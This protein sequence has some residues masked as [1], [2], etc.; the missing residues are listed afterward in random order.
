MGTHG[1]LSLALLILLV[2]AATP[3]EE[4]GG[5]YT[6]INS[7]RRLRVE[8]LMQETLTPFTG[9][10]HHPS[11]KHL[12]F[13]LSALW[14]NRMTEEG[15][16]RLRQAY[17]D[18][19]KSDAE[20]PSEVMTPNLAYSQKWGNMR[21]WLRI[22]YLFNSESSHKP[23]RLAPDVE[24][25]MR[26]L[27]WNFAQM[28][29][30]PLRRTDPDCDWLIMN[31]ENH[32]IM[33]YG[34]SFLALQAIRNHPDYR[35]RK[36]EDGHT[37][38]E[39]VTAWTEYYRR[40]CDSR[41]DSGLF[42]EISP[43][44][45]KWFLPELI[46]I[47]DFADDPVLR[48]KME[49]L[50]HLT[51]ADWAIDQLGGIRGGGKTRSYPDHYSTRGGSDSWSD[52]MRVFLDQNGDWEKN[53]YMNTL[54]PYYYILGTAG[55]E[56]PDLVM[57]LALDDEARGEYEYTSLRPARLAKPPAWEKVKAEEYRE[58]NGVWGTAL[59]YWMDGRD[60]RAV[61]YSYCT[62]DYIMGSWFE[63]PDAEYAGIHT[64]N[65]WQ[66]VVFSTGPNARVYPDCPVL[67]KKANYRQHQA[68]QYKNVLVVQKNRRSKDAGGMRVGFADGMKSRVVE[69]DGWF[70]LKEGS[71]YLA[72][73]TD[74]AEW[75]DGNCLASEDE[76]LPIVFVAGREAEHP[77]MD[78]F[79]AY[80][81]SISLTTREETLICSFRDPSGGEVSL[82]MDIGK[83]PSIP[84]VNG[85]PVNL[86]PKRVF[87]S[88][89]LE[90]ER[91][92]G[93]VT[94]RRADWKLELD[95]GKSE[96]HESGRPKSGL[97][98]NQ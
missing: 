40:Y 75:A 96:S 4:Q 50:I 41:A 44:Y 27:F 39:H 38:G 32:D 95:F 37:L 12:Q 74:K 98:G 36:L 84:T 15:N 8:R 65:R 45:G 14:L 92:S 89:F 60:P 91:G 70:F 48:K 69:R 72:V 31:S 67:Q 43:T 16:D 21:L 5:R 64:Q 17:G 88:P 46:N 47:C 58:W 82:G 78:D 94:I 63:D 59:A 22:Y 62:P 83:Q 29:M 71:A 30:P 61:R 20:N 1:I 87:D 3:A 24:E 28:R 2:A 49:L 35:D 19:L 9:E 73:H 51:C 23:G 7:A 81:S 93:V 42:A 76:F 13:A 68:V 34:N 11:Q 66:G 53:Y 79:T 90:S 52:M 77:T 85:K 26:D 55:Y 80:V 25:K 56:M 18:I 6:E 86:K 33:D 54:H 10:G 97:G 57:E